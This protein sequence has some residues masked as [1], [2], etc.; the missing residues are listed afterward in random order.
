MF[1]L[2]HI[3][4]HQQELLRIKYL[5]LEF[6]LAGGFFCSKNW[7]FSPGTFQKVLFQYVEQSVNLDGN[8]DE[9]NWKN[10]ISATECGK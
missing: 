4:R 9:N 2:Q 8:L 6:T 10:L 5:V 7:E 1:S 3:S